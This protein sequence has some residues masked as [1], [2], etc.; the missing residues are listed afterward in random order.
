[1]DGLITA[2][3]ESHFTDHAT[4][5]GESSW[6]SRPLYSFSSRG[7]IGTWISFLPC[8]RVKAVRRSGAVHTRREV[9]WLRGDT[10]PGFHAKPVAIE[11]LLFSAQR[12]G[13]KISGAVAVGGA[14]M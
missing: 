5:T 3:G 12:F 14:Q 1:M 2:G 13:G 4:R 10:D 8:V 9:P 11:E 6:F 7:L